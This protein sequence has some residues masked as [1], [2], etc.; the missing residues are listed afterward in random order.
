MRQRDGVI[1]QAINRAGRLRGAEEGG[2]AEHDCVGDGVDLVAAAV[3]TP[4]ILCRDPGAVPLERGDELAARGGK[5][6]A[7]VTRQG[8]LIQ[9]KRRLCRQQVEPAVAPVE[10]PHEA[11]VELGG[12]GQ[13]TTKPS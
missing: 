2:V 7:G 3:A 5:Q 10:R 13:G 4:D 8:T 6:E 12:E 9:R 1:A 11:G